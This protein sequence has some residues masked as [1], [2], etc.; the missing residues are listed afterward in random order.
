MEFLIL[1]AILGVVVALGIR[2]FIGETDARG[3]AAERAW[4]NRQQT[5]AERLVKEHEFVA[6]DLHV[7]RNRGSGIGFDEQSLRI[8]FLSGPNRGD[9]IEIFPANAILGAEVKIDETSVLQTATGQAFG[10]ALAGGILAGGAGAVVGGATA[11]KVQADLVRSVDLDVRVDDPV[12]PVRRVN[13]FSV[14][15]GPGVERSMAQ[16]FMQVMEADPEMWH[17]RLAVLIDR[18]SRR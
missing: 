9:S 5:F 10:R 6:S 1:V 16:A 13:F 3:E 4:M 8:A 7:S 14:V 18:N 2:S 12:T 11:N 15:S 17:N